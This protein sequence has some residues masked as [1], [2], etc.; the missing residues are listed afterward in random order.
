MTG[1]PDASIV[2]G[3]LPGSVRYVKLGAGGR[4]WKAAKTLGQ[5]YFGWKSVPDEALASADYAVIEKAI[6]EEY[7]PKPGATQDFRAI[8]S[9]L[10][11]PSRHVWVTYQ[12][13]S[14][15][16]CTVHDGIAINP[17][18]EGLDLG[19]FWLTC[20]RTWSDRSLGGRHLVLSELPGI[21]GATSGFQGTACTPGGWR[22]ILRILSDSEDPAVMAAAQAR[23]AY[24]TAVSA[25]VARLGP[26][27]FEL[28]VDLLLSRTGWSRLEKLGGSTEGIDIEVENPALD[29][30]AFVQVKSRAAQSVLDDYVGRFLDRRERCA[31]MIFAVHSPK[32]K[33]IPP[34]DLPV[35][36]WDGPRIAHLVVRLGLGDW[37]ANRI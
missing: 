35:Q 12:E 20:D 32:G 6:R 26:K 1:S 34:P 8:R 33:L 31:R 37:V 10:D 36:V 22:E 30:I 23:G 11:R 21:V 19:H 25:L 4:W 18:G 15:W 5:I 28:L 13:G 3:A 24:E 29:E 27:D 7:G 16:W 17:A 14:L 2:A 9:V